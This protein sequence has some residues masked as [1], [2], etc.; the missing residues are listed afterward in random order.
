MGKI[1]TFF[2][3]AVLP[4]AL[5]A[6]QTLTLRDGTQFRGHMISATQ[7]AISFQDEN[8]DNHRFHLSEVQYMD[9]TGGAIGSGNPPNIFQQNSPGFQQNSPGGNDSNRPGDRPYGDQRAYGDRADRRP[10]PEY[11]NGSAYSNR[12]DVGRPREE[13]GVVPTATE[14]TVRTNERIDS[15][16]AT[17]GR[18]YS[19]QVARDVLDTNGAVLIPRGADA[20]LVIRNASQRG[21]INGPQLTLDVESVTIDGARYLVSTQ[22]VQQGSDQNIGKNRRTAE[23]V[24]GGAVLGTLLGAIA[25]GGKGAAIGLIA[26]AAAGGTAQ[27]LTRGKEVRVPAETVLTFRLDQPIRLQSM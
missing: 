5:S 18:T 10:A 25:G 16:T 24:G 3:A 22:D 19:A 8:G 12:T 23:M 11:N 13:S 21:T 17:E 9:F 4:L 15:T 6:Q 27:V 26:G 14:F 2:L 20:Q 1:A 7:N